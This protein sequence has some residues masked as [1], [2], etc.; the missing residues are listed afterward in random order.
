MAVPK[1]R[2]L[3]RGEPVHDVPFDGP[4]LRI[5]RMKEND[6]VINNLSVSRFHAT[7]TREEGG[8]RLKDLGSENGC[9]VN[10]RRVVESRVGPGD[11]IQ[12]GKHQLEIVT[13]SD[14]IP[15]RR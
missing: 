12:I 2:L 1:V 10:G 8:F 11:R 15:R 5:G 9:W 6:V 4:A 7:L 13:S 14:P 3:L